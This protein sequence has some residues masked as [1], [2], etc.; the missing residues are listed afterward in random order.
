MKNIAMVIAATSFVS[1]AAFSATPAFE[2]DTAAQRM[3]LCDFISARLHAT[4]SEIND[5]PQIK[6]IQTKTQSGT[7]ELISYETSSTQVT[8]LAKD[9]TPIITSATYLKNH[10]D[11]S[12]NKE[13]FL[14]VLQKSAK[15]TPHA[16]TSACDTYTLT[17]KF[18]RG[19]LNEVRIS[20]SYLD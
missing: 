16:F 3:A 18:S 6:L 7:N 1:A 4:T 20:S 14:S 2:A 17:V 10:F 11:G 13:A 12:F 8:Y 15:E 9:R 5:S 19:E